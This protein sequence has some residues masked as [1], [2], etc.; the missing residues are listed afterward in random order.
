MDLSAI[1]PD[2]DRPPRAAD[3]NAA[4]VGLE[5]WL[6]AA[7]SAD[8]KVEAEAF[9]AAPGG[10]RMLNAL[11]GN[12]PF[13]TQLA[14]KE[15]GFL[16][17][18]PSAGYE[19]ARDA[20]YDDLRAMDPA[21]TQAVTSKALRVAKRRAALLIALA[22]L[23]GAW[24]LD[25]ITGT[26]SRLAELCLDASARHALN[27]LVSSGKIAVDLGKVTLDNCGYVLLGMGKLGA[28]ELN[29]SSDIDIIVLYDPERLNAKDPDRLRQDMVRATQ[30]VVNLMQERTAD[31]YVFRTDL[32][33]RPD[34][35]MTPLAMTVSAA[36]SYYET[37]GQNWE[38]AAMIKARPVA[39]DCDLGYA[40]LEHIRPFVWRKHL[41]FAAVADIH[42]IKRQINAHRGGGQVA[43]EG[44]NVKLGRG[45]IREIEFFAQT[46]QLIWGGRTPSL[47][48]RK[49]LEAIDRLADEGHTTHDAAAR[50][51][52]S[53]HF[54]R[55]L[56]H[57]LQMVMDEQTQKMPATEEGVDAIGVF[58]GF[59]DPA[60]FREALLGH[61]RQVE[62]EYAQLFEDEPDLGSGR[63]LVFTGV[64]DDPETVETLTDMGFENASHVIGR[65][66]VWH[67]GRYR[68]TRSERAR[69]LLTELMPRLLESLAATTNPVQAFNRFDTF[70]GELPSGVQLLSLFHSNPS[71]L[72]MVSEIM[73]N[74]P[75]LAIWLSRH[76]SLLDGVI[77]DDWSAE[78]AGREEMGQ[79]L[80]RALSLARDFQDVLDIVIRWANDRRFQTGVE[81]LQGRRTG[82]EAGGILTLVAE[83]AV[84]ALTRAVEDEFREPHGGWPD[85]DKGGE[86]GFAVLAFGK[87]GGRE[88][89]PMSDLDLVFVYNVPADIDASDGKRPL[90]PMVY[91][92]RLGQRLVTAI[93][94]QTG[95]GNLYEVDTRLRPNGRS[96]PVCTQYDGFKNYYQGE[97]WTWEFMA[98]T[99]ARPIY[100]PAGLQADLAR[101]IED[102]I[103]QP[104]DAK[105]LV[106][107]VDTMRQRI[108]KQYPGEKPWEI[109]HRPGGLVDIEFI[110]QYLQLRH[111]A[112]GKDILSTN[113]GTALE[114]LA[115]AGYL[116][117]AA[118]E[119][120]RSALR[121]WRNIQ[122]AIR[123]TAQEG[124]DEDSAPDGQKS[125]LARCGGFDDFQSLRDHIDAVAEDVREC[126]RQLVAAP[127]EQARQEL[128][129]ED[130]AQG[131]FGEPGHASG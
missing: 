77:S 108:R 110:A 54:L 124:L 119:T 17:D 126:Y 12:S 103:R 98:L 91:F 83:T 114:K 92:S 45:G 105:A 125:L 131:E 88:M 76:P 70:L 129:A 82:E 44:H 29:Y 75:R 99:R 7:Q 130:V 51:R 15:I 30:T 8:R 49:T 104:R 33:L 4:R 2:P 86:T 117:P 63:S 47:R 52:E 60:A 95:E 16:L 97:A 53:Y 71:L 106:R 81:L 20:L 32:R 112:E 115:A 84:D 34:P 96:G 128:G 62:Q 61:L 65:I 40:F 13:L 38:R 73:G 123:L 102:A 24:T 78:E 85:A 26:L 59:D 25:D 127:A 122:A 87:V 19:A 46:Q 22:D 11:F 116:D 120:L 80:T 55:T 14:V 100:G 64:E 1:L 21:S 93:T 31:G 48:M 101:I 56:E 74:A 111:A 107:D 50:L 3:A 23:T 121:L 79:N 118:K 9:L 42:S 68:A 66:R 69:Q 57:R 28:G 109:K 6:E 58:M 90:T 89:A 18:L 67:H 27:L 10:E 43:I 35:G 94:S 36:E 113:T 37:I 72:D 41:D 5:R 39:G